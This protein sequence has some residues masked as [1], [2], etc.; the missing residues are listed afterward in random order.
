MTGG[1]AERL[2][3]TRY[4]GAV[5]GAVPF[6]LLVLVMTGC[7][8]TPSTKATAGGAPASCPA[9]WRAGW[10]A[11]ANRIHAPVYC[12]TWM[13]DPLDARIGGRFG[14]GESVS[15]D[16]SYLV[17]FF[18]GEPGSGEVHVNFR[19][20]PG[21][22]R[23]PTCADLDTNKPVPCFSDPKDKARAGDIVARMYTANQGADQW[24]VLYAWKRG[25]SLYTISEHVAPPYTHATVVRNLNRMLKGLVLLRPA[26]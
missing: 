17:S 14:N 13:P 1:L 23:I 18:W 9:A 22:P 2:R 6:A 21:H 7:G 3:S 25:G 20:Y 15:R 16:R 5:K 4:K 12:P 26:S 8:S 11:L 10:Q 24:H 19:S